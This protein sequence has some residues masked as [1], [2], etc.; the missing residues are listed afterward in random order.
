MI[1][2]KEITKLDDLAALVNTIDT[3]SWVES[4]EIEPG[5]YS[6]ADLSKCL[7]NERHVFC[8]A[9]LDGQFSGMASAFVMPKPDGNVWLYIDEV[10]VCADKQQKGV[11]KAL[12]KFLLNYAKEHGCDEVW[13]GT[14][15]DNVAAN[16]LYTSL[17]PA[18]VEDFVG[19]TY[20]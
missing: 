10:D 3:A 16:A 6:V 5:D 15:K 1:E 17:E 13:L 11:G 2:V 4:S 18:E 20:K 9:S 12:M 14:E 19:Y 8:I 7:G